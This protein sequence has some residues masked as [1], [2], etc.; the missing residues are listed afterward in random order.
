LP[1]RFRGDFECG[2]FFARMRQTNC[3]C[4]RIDNVNRTA[5]GNMDTE[6]NALLVCNDGVAPD[7]FFVRFKRTVE[8]RDPVCVNLF[9]GNERPICESDLVP[10][11]LMRSV[12]PP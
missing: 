6:R 3:R 10:N 11:L 7:K 9:N 1:D 2:S 4:F 8:N 12:K 5:V